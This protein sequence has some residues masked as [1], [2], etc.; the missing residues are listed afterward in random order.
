MSVRWKVA[1]VVAG[2][3][4]VAVYGAL[5]LAARDVLLGM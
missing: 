1:F 3:V 5:A 2:V 4:C